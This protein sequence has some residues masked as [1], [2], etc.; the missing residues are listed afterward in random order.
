MNQIVTTLLAKPSY[1]YDKT[2]DA[3][4][5]TMVSSLCEMLMDDPRIPVA[6]RFSAVDKI[7]EVYRDVL[8]VRDKG[9]FPS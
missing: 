7:R 5:D 6:A 2:V 3:Y 4:V 1:L 9:A 8:S